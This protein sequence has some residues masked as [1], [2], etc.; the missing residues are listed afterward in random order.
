MPHVTIA[1][2]GLLFVLG[3][4]GFVAT[5]SSHFTALIPAIAGGIFEALGAMSLVLPQQKKH[6]MHAAA[7]VGV[8][9]FFGCIPGLIKLAKWA[10]GTPP[11]RTA[12]V[13]SQS[14]MAF[15]CLLFVIL[16][17]R[18]F[19]QARRAREQQGFPVNPS[20]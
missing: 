13:I 2:G 12:A 6:F 20:S 4:A 7:M 5:G 11:E 1:L 3:I 8:L 19:V 14:I 10:G 9:G 17:V 15:L 18:S 16:C